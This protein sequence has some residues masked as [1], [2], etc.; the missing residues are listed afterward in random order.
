MSEKS[1]WGQFQVSPTGEERTRS[2]LNARCYCPESLHLQDLTQRN[3]REA[4]IRSVE[5]LS[6]Q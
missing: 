4:S 5:Q 1:G 6:S 2:H 3:Q